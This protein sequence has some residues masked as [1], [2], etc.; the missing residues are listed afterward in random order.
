MKCMYATC[1]A[2][3]FGFVLVPERTGDGQM[4]SEFDYMYQIMLTQ[5]NPMSRSFKKI[6]FHASTIKSQVTII[7][8]L[9]PVRVS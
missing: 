5:L 6:F 8:F 9:S 2:F 3:A 7:A 1:A 4:L